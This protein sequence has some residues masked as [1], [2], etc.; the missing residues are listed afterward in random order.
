MSEQAV[1]LLSGGIDS[2]TTAAI[3]ASRGLSIHAI[4]FSYG[5][6]HRIE[7]RSAKKLARSLGVRDHVII[8]IPAGIFSSALTGRKGGVPKGRTIGGEIPSTYVPARNILFLSYALAW[9]E[10]IGARRIFIGATAVDYSGYPDCRPGFFRAFQEMADLGTRAG[11]EG[12]GI[13][14]ETPLIDLTKGEI[15]R[16]GTELGV[17]YSLTLSCYDPDRRGRA[18]GACDSCVL[19]RKG[20]AEAGVADPTRYVAI[21]R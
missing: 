4:T 13:A 1:V 19:R 7:I 17:D 11:V 10:S 14:V 9:G 12:R 21:P 20:F 15:I 3:A 2:A 8:A 5:Q 18:C 6:R 16:R